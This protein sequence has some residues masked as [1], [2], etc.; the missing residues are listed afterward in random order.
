MSVFGLMRRSMPQHLDTAI[1]HYLLTI[2][3]NGEGK[4]KAEMGG[5]CANRG[6]GRWAA[7]EHAQ[8][9][10]RVRYGQCLQRLRGLER[11]GVE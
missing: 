5:K 2:A 11:G 8:R 10:W 4:A 7:T 6:T 1:C 3:A 9:V